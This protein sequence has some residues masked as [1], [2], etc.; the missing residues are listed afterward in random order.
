VKVRI[1]SG[2]TL[3]ELDARGYALPGRLLAARE[4]EAL[5]RC[6]GDD[7]RF[8][9]SIEMEPLRYGRG[10]YRY[11]AYP[12]PPLVQKLRESLYPPLAGSRTAGRSSSQGR[13]LEPELDGRALPRASARRLLLHPSRHYNRAPGR[14]GPSRSRS[15][16]R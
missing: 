6:F 1:D 9:S 15:R 11:F 12:L 4:C 14:H 7:A 16:W 10:R 5:R 13:A 3:T 2:R 8:R